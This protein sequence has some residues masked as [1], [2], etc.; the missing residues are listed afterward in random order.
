HGRGALRALLIQSGKKLLE[1][2]N[3]LQKWGL[4][5][6]SRRG[7]NKAAVAV[8]RKLCVALWHVL[9][10][11]AI[12]ALER[13]SGHPSGKIIDRE[14]AYILLQLFP[15]YCKKMYQLIAEVANDRKDAGKVCVE[16]LL[17]F[18]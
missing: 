5:V 9:M 4:A 18:R 12:G 11:H 1:V 14:Q 13:Q 2:N 17:H 3:P 10:G 16:I 8:A 15:R 7:R 6:A